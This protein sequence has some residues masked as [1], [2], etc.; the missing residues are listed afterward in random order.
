MIVFITGASAGF[1]AEMARTFVRHGHQVV[2]SG[3]AAATPFIRE[4]AN[5]IPFSGKT[6]TAQVATF[7]D[8]AHYARQ[9][10]KFKDHALFA[11]YAPADHPQIAFA[12]VVENAGFG[13]TA[14]APVAAKLVKYWCV[15][16]LSNPLPA[17]RGRMVDPFAPQQ[18]QEPEAAE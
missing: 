6:G 12:V 17:P 5:E 18:P 14:A 13:S 16:R 4:I 1:G 3:T 11:G 9:A 15:E 8:K 2:L 7:V 10:K